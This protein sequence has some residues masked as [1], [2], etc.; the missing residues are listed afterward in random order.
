MG[1]ISRIS[2]LA[3]TVNRSLQLLST[4]TRSTFLRLATQRVILYTVRL[5]SVDQ[6]L[7]NALQSQQLQSVHSNPKKSDQMYQLLQIFSQLVIIK[8]IMR[9][10]HDKNLS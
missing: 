3:V 5:I 6:I 9:K 8:D 2:V 10:N 4:H 1:Y 7:I